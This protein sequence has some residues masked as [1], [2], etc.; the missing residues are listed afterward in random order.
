MEFPGLG[1]L[2]NVCTIIAGAALGVAIGA[3][4]SEKLRNLVTDI[5]GLVTL[6]AATSALTP[7]WSNVYI[8]ELPKGW[9]LLCILGSLLIGALI[10]SALHLEEKLEMLGENL[11]KK[12]RASAESP[13]IEGFLN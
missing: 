13:F 11:R 5:L 8:S 6:L 1:T 12:F 9:G 3:K 2:I 7:L 4:V 10:G